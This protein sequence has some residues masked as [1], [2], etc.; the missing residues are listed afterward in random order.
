MR[1]PGE[2][3]QAHPHDETQAHRPLLAAAAVLCGRSK[4]AERQPAARNEVARSS[5]STA[6]RMPGAGKRRRSRRMSVTALRGRTGCTPV[7]SCVHGPAPGGAGVLAGSC[8]PVRAH[9][10]RR[11][12]PGHHLR[13]ESG[14]TALHPDVER[15]R[16]RAPRPFDAWSSTLS[17]RETV[18]ACLSLTTRSSSP[19]RPSPAQQAGSAV[20]PLVDPQTVDDRVTPQG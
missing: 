7:T 14:R 11:R 20:H 15:I 9:R 4:R 1:L 10:T 2:T 13:P 8:S 18:P 3:G 17:G 5:R 19:R 12:H 16:G 6:E